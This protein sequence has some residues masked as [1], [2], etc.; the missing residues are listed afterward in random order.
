MSRNHQGLGGWM[1]LVAIKNY[2]QT[3]AYGAVVKVEKRISTPVSENVVFDFSESAIEEAESTIAP[4]SLV[5][6]TLDFGDRISN[7]GWSELRERGEK[8]YIWGRLDY[9]DAFNKPRFTA[10]QMVHHFAQI[11]EFTYCKRGNG[12]EFRLN[13]WWPRGVAL[14][15]CKG[16]GRPGAGLSGGRRA[17]S[18][19]SYYEKLDAG[20]YL[21][22][23]RVRVRRFPITGGAGGTSRPLMHVLAVFARRAIGPVNTNPTHYHIPKNEII[24][25]MRSP[26]FAICLPASRRLTGMPRE[27]KSQKR[28]AD[29]VGNAVQVTRIK[30]DPAAVSLGRRGGK[31][32]AEA[33]SQERRKEIARQAAEKRWSADHR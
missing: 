3:P 33:L 10:F 26:T 15:F 20:C 5:T 22:G 31:A 13:K 28:R 8:G 23:F 4:G 1:A 17:G 14:G 9:I 18:R 21:T 29:V 16:R 7:D 2:G 27:P 6:L 30:K 32:R 24:R 25:H 19:L 12:T 11:Y